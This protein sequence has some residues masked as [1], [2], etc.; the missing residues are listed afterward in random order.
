MID[1]KEQRALRPDADHM[2]CA[3]SDGAEAAPT[4]ERI[5]RIRGAIH[6]AGYSMCLERPELLI[7]FRHSRE[8]RHY[9]KEHPAV[10]RAAALAFVMANRGARVYDDELIAGGMTAKRVAANYY[11]E[12]ASI[13]MLEDLFRLK[14][15][16]VPIRLSR[17]ERVKLVWI[18]ART[19]RDSVFYRALS[20]PKRLRH[21]WEML[22]AERYMVTEQAGV[23]HQAGNYARVI[24]DGL[25]ATDQ[26]AQRCLDEDATPGGDQLNDD[27]RAF[28]RSVRLV[29]Q[30]IRQMAENLADEALRSAE[31][32]ETTE[33]R[34]GELTELA[35]TLRR[36]PWL[37][38]RNFREGLQSTWLMHVALCLEDY[39]QS[40][41]FGRLD[42]MLIDLYREDLAQGALT[43]E[44]AVELTAAFELKCCEIIPAYS[45]RM[46]QYFGGNDVQYA[47]TLG[48]VDARG[49]GATNELSGVFLDAYS[50]IGTR[51]PAVM[52][53]IHDASPSW[54]MD[55]CVA[56]L[57]RTGA[58]PAFFGDEAVIRAMRNAGFSEADARD[59]GIVGCTEPVAPGRTYS[60]ADAAL[61]NMPLNLEL[62]LNE[63]RSF[64]G[65]RC[66]TATPPVA[67]LQ[68][69]DAVLA[70]Y[71]EQLQHSVD[72][73]A[74]VMELL[75]QAARV[76]RTTPVNSLLTDG[77]MRSG[78]DVT[79]GG[80]TY[81]FTGVQGVGLAD[82]GESLYAIDQLVFKQERFT[83]PELAE[84]LRRDF[85][86]HELL[87]T[88]LQKKWDRYGNGTG[89]VD[90]WVQVAADAWVETVERH[91][92]SRGGRWIAGFY[93]M[94]CGY[95]FGRFTGALPNGRR[96]G[97]RLSNG[98]SP[99]NGAERNGPTAMLRSVASLD[100]SRWS[101]GHV[102][103]AT[104]E[105]G[106]IGDAAGGARLASLLRHYLCDQQ[107]MQIQV[108]VLSGE[109]LLEARRNPAAFPNL[110]VRVSGYCA[111]FADLQPDVQAEI[112]GRTMHG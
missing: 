6:D 78:A 39:E 45:T 96:A 71:R 60:S 105:R 29:A 50:L 49:E 87:A 104:F 30:G 85:A 101:N 108:A 10:R 88:E 18:A 58:R 55:K 61:L 1:E 11:P 99:V 57:R 79:W 46:D 2:S 102:L 26:L 40:L 62:A 76:H 38:A 100:R 93:S 22:H 20:K 67:Q 12:G 74:G 24:R 27:A 59:Y 7:K 16:A 107:G 13:N 9:R 31:R 90:H 14:N 81:D 103:N 56:T 54:F 48:G 73:M 72:S 83:L 110:L 19:V 111:Y 4:P 63:G 53:R 8:G 21:V 66:G 37:P 42:Q 23:A 64:A 97:T 68:N 3:I 75:E 92:N 77:C 47:I 17:R 98:I 94:T 52:A 82:V 32:P 33:A 65:K 44:Q 51:E 28:Y 112:I 43:Q 84:I 80:A 36:V 41:S 34:R 69:M 25:Q 86:G 109:D 70:A 5:G 91:A 89:A 106:T 35:E 15:R 95:G